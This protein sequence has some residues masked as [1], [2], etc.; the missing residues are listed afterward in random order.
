VGLVRHNA[1]KWQIDPERV[2]I[3]GF[4]AGG[5]VAAM[6]CQI[7]APLSKSIDPIDAQN[8]RPSF[9]VLVYPGRS[10]RIEPNSDSPPAL[11]ICGY[12]DRVDISEGMANVYLK[13][14]QARVPA[15]LHI[16][17][18]AGHGF[19]M[20]SRNQGAVSKWPDRLLEW[21]GDR[22]LLNKG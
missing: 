22:G 21:M 11:I 18:E 4:S 10:Q 7:L 15:E 14:R 3:L 13:F 20:R 6:S 8:A 1:E 5:E 19:G 12:D 2:G 16:Y 9:Q 17:S